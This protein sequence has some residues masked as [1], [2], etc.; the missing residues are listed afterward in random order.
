[1]DLSF[2]DF[3]S[4]SLFV[5]LGGWLDGM[6]SAIAQG[7]SD[8][9][10][11]GYDN[12]K[13]GREHDFAVRQQNDAQ[14]FTREQMQN[15]HQWEVADLKAA[16]LNPVLSAHSGSQ[17]GSSSVTTGNSVN[18]GRMVDLSSALLAYKQGKLLDEQRSQIAEQKANINADTYK[19]DAETKLASATAS[20]AEVEAILKQDYLNSLTPKQRVDAGRGLVHSS[21]VT[22]SVSS[23]SQMLD[24][25]FSK[26]IRDYRASVAENA[27]S[28]ARSK[29]WENTPAGKQFA[30]FQRQERVKAAHDQKQKTR[31]KYK[32][33]MGG[34]YSSASRGV[35]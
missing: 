16:G 29:A 33:R 26:P 12:Y 10:N 1:M 8:T 28:N 31:Q 25:W 34:G 2:L 32:D 35:Y 14:N 11:L 18:T 24:N 4:I 9:V 23:A 5:C 17:I 15:K 6:I 20:K 3:D 13:T 27:R 21:S 22:D 30:E 7:V 19:K